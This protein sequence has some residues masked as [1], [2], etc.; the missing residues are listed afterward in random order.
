MDYGWESNPYAILTAA[1]DITQ[2]L[3][4]QP[5]HLPQP[6]AFPPPPIS[7]PHPGGIATVCVLQL[8]R[9]ICVGGGLVYERA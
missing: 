3:L 8:G 6:L 2:P 1:L 5:A 7:P 4:I 9:V